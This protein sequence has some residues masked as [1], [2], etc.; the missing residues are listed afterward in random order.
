[1][2]D[3]IALA[4]LHLRTVW[5]FR[6][7]AL[8]VATIGCIGG[9]LW[10]MQIPNMYESQTKVFFDT[11]TM[12]RPL[13]RG[14][15]VDDQVAR[16]SVQLISRTLLARP[17]LE[18]VARKTDMDLKVKTP[19]EMDALLTRLSKQIQVQKTRRDKIF[20]ISYKNQDPKLATRV[21]EAILN[22]FVERSLGENR[23]DSSQTKRFIDEQIKEYE[24]RLVSAEERLKEFKRRNLGQ[25]PGTTGG[26][27]EKLQAM[28]VQIADAKL[29]LQEAENRRD[30][31]KEQLED[32]DQWF[33]GE[34]EFALDSMGGHPLDG[35]IQALEESLDQLLLKYTERHPDVAGTRRMLEHLREE[36]DADMESSED[37]GTEED[38]EPG[39]GR[40][41][42][43][44]PVFQQLK[45]A[46]GEA[47]AIIASIQARV[48]EYGKRKEE[49]ERLVETTLQV[50]AEFSRL[51]RDY[52][53]NKRNYGELIERRE[54]LTLSE[55]VRQKTDDIQ[56]N[57]IEPPRVPVVP[58]SPKRPMLNGAVL[59]V[60]L[61]AGLGFAWLIGML[62]PGLYT[63][64]E[65][66]AVAEI[67]VLGVVSRI[68]TPKEV[69]RRRM[70]FASFAMGCMVLFA[71]FGGLFA[72]ESMEID[73]VSKLQDLRTRLL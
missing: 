71:M 20:V 56:F 47:E 34:D 38:A 6:W 45:I 10:V 9:W 44:N 7:V 23:K 61:G 39:L 73:L 66:S 26:Y 67:P 29:E 48:E 3:L 37:F 58:V 53:L 46:L 30:E 52:D 14:L 65:F 28:N 54:S 31:L 59:A 15:A 5:R 13:L 50:E 43:E 69:F 27:F 49:L 32:V 40:Q 1:M 18:E 8:T 36:R 68:L 24:S 2:A 70:E 41:Q 72:L 33:D 22:M 11:Q 17:N 12:L 42:I 63:K 60:G 4:M 62:R 19:K 64:E 51:N 21:V 25:M 16:S 57:I 35:R 55:E